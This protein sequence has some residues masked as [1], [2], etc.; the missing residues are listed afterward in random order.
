MKDIAGLMK[1][2][3]EMQQRMEQAQAELDQME[4]IGEAGGG[5]VSVTLTAKGEMRGV[6]IDP[7]LMTSDERE[8]V[9]DLIKAAHGEAKRKADEAQ[10]K[11]MAEAAKSLPI[12]P[13]IDLPFGIK[14]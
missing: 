2:A 9:E 1:Q 8:V 3:Q 12:P 11:M 6:S 10:Q 5:L 4:V 7:S 14:P 13:G